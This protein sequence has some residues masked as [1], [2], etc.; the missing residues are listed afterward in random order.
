M[1]YD[2]GIVARTFRFKGDFRVGLSADH[3]QLCG[4]TY[5]V[6]SAR[7]RDLGGDEWEHVKGGRDRK[8]NAGKEG[9]GG[10]GPRQDTGTAIIRT[11]IRAGSRINKCQSC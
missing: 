9:R 11:I 4:T 2:S 10:I 7:V 6:T 5:R 3:W 8:R 1:D